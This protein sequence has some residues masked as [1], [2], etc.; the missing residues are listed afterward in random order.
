MEYTD[1][2]FENT[3][4]SLTRPASSC[5]KR[6]P[7]HDGPI[8]D[9]TV[10]QHLCDADAR[11]PTIAL[12]LLALLTQLLQHRFTLYCIGARWHSLLLQHRSIPRCT[13]VILCEWCRLPLRL[14]R[15]DPLS[16][17]LSL[18]L[19]LLTYSLTLLHCTTA[20]ADHVQTNTN[21][22]TTP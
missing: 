13:R 6:F 19:S 12:S 17:S 14:T 11:V 18:S 8:S 9:P 22:N 15:E 16:L 20:Q 5:C 3:C 10:H 4:I 1:F 7:L 21:T 2:S